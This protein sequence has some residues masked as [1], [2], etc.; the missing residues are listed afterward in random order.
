MRGAPI[1]GAAP[2]I[3]NRANPLAVKSEHADACEEFA[4]SDQ[5]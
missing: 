3:I 4:V 5:G 2:E 1:H